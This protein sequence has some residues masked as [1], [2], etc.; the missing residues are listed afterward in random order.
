MKIIDK[1]DTPFKRLSILTALVGLIVLISSFSIWL[2]NSYP[3]TLLQKNYVYAWRTDGGKLKEKVWRVD[4]KCVSDKLIPFIDKA[5]R[6]LSD[7]ESEIF[8]LENKDNENSIET[9]INRNLTQEIALKER[10][11]QIQTQLNLLKSH[12]SHYLGNPAVS[13]SEY[14][15]NKNSDYQN[16]IKM[17]A[18][19]G[20]SE[21]EILDW[22][23]ERGLPRTACIVG[24]IG[25]KPVACNTLEDNFEENAQ[26]SLLKSLNSFDL[27]KEEKSAIKSECV[28]EAEISFV[29]TQS[30]YVSDLS[31]W[32]DN[33]SFVIWLG[34][35]LVICGAAGS[36]F[37]N[38]SRALYNRILR[39]AK[40]FLQKLLR[41]I[42]TGKIDGQ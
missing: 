19:G 8:A 21:Q 9:I 18:E 2:I 5:Q 6:E 27:S 37:Y 12:V 4:G 23:E 28:E 38:R 36:V 22:I 35:I 10:R 29:P 11:L 32:L 20:F 40:Y 7:R 39:P 31:K 26:N 30:Y 15:L 24:G 33:N 14:A 34:V 17:L 16:A 1:L 42:K 25:H 13:E 3:I 41:W